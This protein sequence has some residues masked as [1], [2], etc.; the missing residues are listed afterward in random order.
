MWAYYVERFAKVNKKVKQS[1]VCWEHASYLKWCR[2]V[3]ISKNDSRESRKLAGVKKR[4]LI[5][6]SVIWLATSF[7]NTLS[8]GESMEMPL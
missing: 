7:S 1:I 6:M 8:I 4:M 2:A 3:T 5:Y